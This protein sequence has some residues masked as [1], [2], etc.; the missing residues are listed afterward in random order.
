MIFFLLLLFFLLVVPVSLMFLKWLIGSLESRY[1]EYWANKNRKEREK[2][3]QA[4]SQRWKAI[5]QA[6]MANDPEYRARNE[7]YIAK[8]RAGVVDA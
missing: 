2:I 1:E 4:G 5:H 8:L 7:A 3:V 6:R